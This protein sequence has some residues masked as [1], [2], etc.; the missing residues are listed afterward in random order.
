MRVCLYDGVGVSSDVAED[1]RF[2]ALAN[3]TRRA[4]LRLVRDEPTP[5]GEL[6][7]RLGLSQPAA[8][9]HL[10]VLRDAGL[11]RA[12]R[13]G[14]SRLYHA[15]HDAIAELRAFF[16]EYWS[17]AVDRLAAAAERGAGRRARAS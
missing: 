4:L 9:Q 17:S 16:D 6:A 7:D 8:S 15:D 14:R 13:A 11:V 5:V 10:A 2:R 12:E 1:E 3:P